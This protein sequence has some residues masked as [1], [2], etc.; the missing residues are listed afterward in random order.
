MNQNEPAKNLSEKGR[1]EGGR[2]AGA[3]RPR[4]AGDVPTH[5]HGKGEGP[6][7]CKLFGGGSSLPEPNDA[8]DAGRGR[9]ERNGASQISI[10][11]VFDGA[12][13]ACGVLIE[14]SSP[15]PLAR[16]PPEPAESLT[17]ACRE[18]FENRWRLPE[19]YS[20]PK[21]RDDGSKNSPKRSWRPQK[22]DDGST[23]P[24]FTRVSQSSP[25]F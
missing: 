23:S 14:R 11:G 5:G 2:R 10:C 1:R 18:P 8:A 12:P 9:S 17:G 6:G 16:A 15:A 25:R 3:Q 21:N 22:W 4:G 19:C 20:R 7:E 24:E 13:Q